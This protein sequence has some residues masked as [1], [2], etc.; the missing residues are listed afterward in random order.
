MGW[1]V[2]L[3]FLDFF[4]YIYALV[5]LTTAC[6]LTDIKRNNVTNIT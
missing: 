2:E 3:D 5:A 6:S 1:I 4:W